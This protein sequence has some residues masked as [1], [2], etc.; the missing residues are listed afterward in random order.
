LFAILPL[1]AQNNYMI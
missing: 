1:K